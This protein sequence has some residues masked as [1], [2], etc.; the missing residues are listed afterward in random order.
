M[1]P[2][3][4]AN[5]RTERMLAAPIAPALARLSAPGMLLVVFQSLVSVGDTYFVGRLGTGP[6]AGLALVFPLIML[7]QMTSA[8]AMGGGVSSA[9]ARALGSGDAAAAR[10]LVVHAL[11]IAA[12]M[13]A[14]FTVLVIALGKP[15]YSL[16]GGRG[17]TLEHALRYSSIVFAG[18]I[19]VWIANTL[20]SVLRGSGNM[21]TPALTLIGAALVHLPLSGILVLRIGIG[22]AGIAYVTTFSI[23]A[24]VMAAVVW[25]SSLLAPR[26]GDW[27]LEW[28]LFREI[29][30]VGAVSSLSA[31]QTV[32]TAVILTGF[33][34]RHG[35]AALAGYGV[36]LRLELL[37]IPLVF[38]VG[39]ALV[40]LVGT[41][42][43]AGRAERAKRIAWVGAGFAASISLVIAIVAS[44]FPLAWVGLFSDDVAVLENGSS[45]LRTVAPFYPMLAAGIA[46]YFASQGAGRV[47]RPILAGTVRLAIVIAGGLMVASLQGVFVVIAAAMIAFGALTA[48]FVASTDWK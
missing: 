4:P 41:H 33:V 12:A 21:L 37:Q 19:A 16:L 25:R 5:P 31:I 6:L 40:V 48:W 35:A 42:I 8:G 7:L 27:A 47:L 34:G 20:S 24:L 13:G 22:G 14:A 2:A 46:L 1:N 26:R 11:V 9:V 18:A 3:R 43:G 28:R 29:L 45:Y 44:I 32:L 36:G 39:Q 15:I 17:E 10:R 30:R 23:A 38:A